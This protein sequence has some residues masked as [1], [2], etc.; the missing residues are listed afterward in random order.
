MT[1]MWLVLFFCLIVTLIN[2]TFAL[3]LSRRLHT[4]EQNQGRMYVQLMDRVMAL[5]REDGPDTTPRP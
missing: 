4:L 5:V 3:A 2:A 1:Q